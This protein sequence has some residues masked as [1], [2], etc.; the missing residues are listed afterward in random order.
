[1]AEHEH[2]VH[3][4]N[5][6]PVFSY[7]SKTIFLRRDRIDKLLTVPAYKTIVLRRD[8]IDKLLTVPTVVQGS[9]D[10]LFNLKFRNLRPTIL[11]A[12]SC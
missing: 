4:V 7:A 2:Y 1:M 12:Y 6:D 5:L 10:I 9:E 11:G 3:Y 8:R